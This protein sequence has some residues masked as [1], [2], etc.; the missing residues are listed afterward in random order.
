MLSVYMQ[1][2]FFYSSYVIQLQI[3][4]DIQVACSR[5]D[6]M[7]IAA[8][9]PSFILQNNLSHPLD[10][11]PCMIADSSLPED[12]LASCL[13]QVPAREAKAIVFWQG[14]SSCD[15][16]RAL[17]LR[18]SI[19]ESAHGW[20][21]FLS[22]NFIRHSF[23][24]PTG[25]SKEPFAATLLTT[26][27][28]EDITYLVVSH[29]PS[30]KLQVQNLC[31]SALEVVESGSKAI[32]VSPQVLPPGCQVAYEPP[33]LAKLYPRVYEE[34]I[35]GKREREVWKA[36]K[37]V[38]IKFRTHLVDRDREEELHEW[39]EPFP[40][41]GDTDRLI[42]IPEAGN[43]LISIHTRGDTIFVTLLPTGSGSPLQLEEALPLAAPTSERAIDFMCNLS[44]VVL[45][46]DDETSNQS[47]ITEILRIIADEVET[48][49][50]AS[51]QKGP[52]IDLTLQALHVDNMTE[53]SL[54]EYAVMLIPRSKHAARA[55]LIHSDPPPL[56]KFSVHYNPHTSNFIE[57]LYVSLQSV[58]V[59]VEDTLLHTLKS[60]FES[61]T[62]PSTLNVAQPSE[63]RYEESLLSV[64]PIVHQ[65]S[66]RD[67]SPLTISSFV[68]E[69]TAVH[70]NARVSLKVLLS[71]NDSPF[72]FSR[73][74]L[75]NVYSNLSELS[76]T[77]AAHY[78]STVIMHVGWLLGSLELI[79]SPGGLIQ[80][81]GRGI[82][83][84]ISLPYEGI[85]RSPS[86]FILGIGRGTAA[87]MQHFSSGAIRSVVNLASSLAR[88]MERL[89]MDPHHISYQ[90]Q[91]RRERPATHFTTGLATGAS[92]FGLSLMSAVAGI[93]D[94]P[95]QSIHKMEESTSTLGAT[96][97]ILGGIGKG[98][99]GVVA[100]PVGGAMDFVSQTGQGIMHGTGLVHKLT[101]RDIAEL[102]AYIGPVQ[103]LQLSATVTKCVM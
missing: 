19:K 27:D 59:Q 18:S 90:D 101:H 34:E 22:P 93:V 60:H 58:T 2:R 51:H 79:G 63:H 82:Q 64:P 7:L 100:K 89:S 31:S 78:F 81:I 85:V 68:I 6:R 102:A 103:R 1:C 16:A 86:L 10:L 61:Y 11:C 74:E 4:G 15:A 13:Q 26:H 17:L 8:I 66:Q 36:A 49:Y 55:K 5:V 52:K 47:T 94:Q 72:S 80:S 67:A 40:L 92:S 32:P 29:D 99:L 30:P 96:K 62:L 42:T 56:L 12:A 84:L 97:T 28:H 75:Q 3:V 70:L 24:L 21:I 48:Q 41:T 65:E 45:C 83:D 44:Q 87:C 37:E 23:A 77:V 69:P 43:M 53:S 20:S 88:N 73:Y 14:S 38:A 98:L 46:L 35:A 54:G 50:L 76:Q 9:R 57:R 95:M 91:Q 25:N 33:A 71:C 39:S